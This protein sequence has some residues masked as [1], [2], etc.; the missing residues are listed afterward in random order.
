[1]GMA[2]AARARAGR[3]ARIV[4]PLL[5]WLA[6]LAHAPAGAMARVDEGERVALRPGEGLLALSIDTDLDIAAVRLKSIDRPLLGGA[7]IER[8]RAGRT[9]RMYRLPAGDYQWSR[10]T[11][12]DRWRWR[13]DIALDGDE[14]FRFS[15]EAGRV[16]YPGDL[17][18]RSSL[19]DRWLVHVSNRS[20][21][22][23][24][25]LRRHHPSTWEALPFAF[26]GRFP[27]PFP[28]HYRQ[29]VRDRPPAVAAGDGPI[30]GGAPD[31]GPAPAPASGVRIAAERLFAREHIQEA[32]ISPDG[33]LGALIV[34][35]TVAGSDGHAES[36]RAAIELFDVAS[37]TLQRIGQS[38]VGFAELQWE[39]DDVLL[40][41]APLRRGSRLHAF[42]VGPAAAGPRAVEA[43]P[44]PVGRVVHLLPEAPRRILFEGMSRSGRFV[45]H[46]LA[47]ERDA[48]SQ[49]Q[50]RDLGAR[51]N[52]GVDGDVGWFA[53][54]RGRLRAAIT[55]REDAAFLVHGSEATGYREALRLD[56]ARDFEP[57]GLSADGEQLYA[58]TDRDRGQ[59]DLVA[60]DLAAGRVSQTLFS[61][62]GIDVAAPVFGADGEPAG[63]SYYENGRLVTEYFDHGARALA[64]RLQA[65][66]PGRSVRIHARSDDDRRMLLWV[67]ASDQPL[68]LYHLDL[69]A[70]RAQLVGDD[71]PQ[72][73]GERFT[74]VQ[75]LR[76]ERA[77]LPAI[78]AFLA[79]PAGNGPRP[80]V[81]MAHGGPIGVADR[82]HFD[83][84]VQFL[85][86]LGFAV[87]QVNFR[88]SDGYGRA[89]RES[90]HRQYGTGIEDDID[91][92]LQWVIER[93]PI[94]RGRMCA[95]GSSYG[96]YS[97]LVS[98][99]RW[100]ERYRCVVSIA[101]VSDRQLF[102][103][104]SD[105]ARSEKVRAEMI[106][107][108]GDP[109]ADADEMQATSPLYHVDRLALPI[110]LVHGRDDL[111]VDYEHSRRLA[112]M[113]ALAGRPPVL[114]ALDDTGHVLE[115]PA[116]R[117]GAWD[118]IAGFLQVHLAP[119]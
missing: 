26:A 95:V 52:R 62:P 83:P 63:A 109:V 8:P 16:N 97:A 58:L 71:M 100:P 66:F 56:E 57:F 27:D 104:A 65:A 36:T 44:G 29:A 24:D 23:I 30:D 7:T 35:E 3:G 105:S 25:W 31:A 115:D 114:L 72:L 13:S 6:A 111:R 85:A 20:L 14:E 49:F 9:L 47:I 78:D 40:V 46:E 75:A 5:C 76:V 91:A 84:E 10:V 53:D 18:L 43:M 39:G 103:T 113:L 21:P 69:D 12:V 50:D 17:V 118:T 102:F 22:V 101:G 86:A 28:A 106:K 80:L 60:Y 34:R 15:V 74:G 98:A 42:V 108:I 99:M 70:R 87:L 119:R 19:D 68:K 4:L 48:M 94:D 110:M 117:A 82:L 64:S 73:S 55:R 77:G 38:D 112:R 93:H 32:A 79:L 54:A 45:V 92:A 1:M 89:F 41:T 67:D 107:V 59:R 61:R 37:G 11:L 90:G 2:A 96:G 51:L 81:V 116:D 33:T 88:G